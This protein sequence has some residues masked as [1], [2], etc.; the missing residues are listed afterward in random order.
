[1]RHIL[2]NFFFVAQGIPLTLCLLGGSL[3][4]GIVLGTL[5]SILQYNNMG[6]FFI[7]R[8]VSFIRGTPLMLQLSFIY[9]T[10]P[11]LFGIKLSI[12]AAGVVSFGLNSAAYMAEI[13][14]AGIENIPKGQF[15]ASKTLGI[16]TYFMWR[17]IVVPQV[18]KNILPGLI[19]EVISLLKETSLIGVISGMDI[20][21]MAQT[22]GAS[23]F[24][25]FM[26]LC[27]AAFYY[28]AFVLFI[29]FVGKVIENKNKKYTMGQKF[30]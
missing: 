3:L 8:Y 9:F 18:V 6:C 5:L 23:Q 13:L 19:N 15:E 1:M 2:D 26:P 22:L 20:M 4:I 21:R 12:L 24:T 14:R 29:E 7:S 28:Y 10:F 30:V 16:P 11:G 25:Y 27:I 17:D